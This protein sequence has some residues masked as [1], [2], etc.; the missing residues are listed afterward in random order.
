MAR[1]FEILI[2]LLY[3]AMKEYTTNI[4]IKR[5]AKWNR[6]S[7][8]YIKHQQPNLTC[9]WEMNVKPEPQRSKQFAA[10]ENTKCILHLDVYFSD[11]L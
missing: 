2:V 11:T 1:P 7:G 9:T 5:V 6:T 3:R 4:Y 10:G 8:N